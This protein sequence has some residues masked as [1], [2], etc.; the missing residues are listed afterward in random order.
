MGCLRNKEVIFG[1]REECCLGILETVATC[2]IF[3]FQSEV[4]WFRIKSQYV[5]KLLLLGNSEL[6]LL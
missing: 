2:L 3:F 5:P 1:V 4:G 6:L